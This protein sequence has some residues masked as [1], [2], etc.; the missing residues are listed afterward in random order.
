MPIKQQLQTILVPAA[1]FIG[2]GGG[3]DY[4]KSQLKLLIKISEDNQAI[5]PMLL[6]PTLSPA[7]KLA[8]FAKKII[9]HIIHFPVT[10]SFKG[11]LLILA[12]PE[13]KGKI[14]IVSY[15]LNKKSG[16]KSIQ[17]IVKEQKNPLLFLTFSPIVNLNCKQIGYIPDLQ[18]ISMP[19]LFSQKERDIR[20]NMFKN[21]LSCCDGIIV[22]SKNVKNH[23]LTEYPEQCGKTKIFSSPCVPIADEYLLDVTPDIS[24]YRLPEKYFVIANQ[25]WVHKDHITAFK[26]LRI[27]YDKGHEEVKIVCTGKTDDYRFP[28]YYQELKNNIIEL[29]LADDIRFL[30]FIPKKDQIT[31]MRQ[32]VGIIQP[33]LFEG[34]PG[35]GAVYDAIS[36]GVPAI[37]SDIAINREIKHPLVSF[38]CVK[39]PNDL[40]Q[41][42]IQLLD[43]PIYRPSIEELKKQKSGN[44]ML[45]MQFL[46][47]V[48]SDLQ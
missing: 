20:D 2:W 40:A 27:L 22:N 39:N 5:K 28:H 7:G 34:G 41:K 30:G 31:I 44:I 23:L 17:K 14:E 8:Y 26:A 21:I 11:D 4:L 33:T 18:H 15:Y 43:G 9:K 10:A 48:F 6:I 35:G 38:F 25:L 12:D 42:M 13:I 37:V 16:K 32:S 24:M 1:G 3:I 29:N 19:Q 47:S 45:G 46:Q 36:Y